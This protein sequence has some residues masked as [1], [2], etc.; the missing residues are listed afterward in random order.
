VIEQL[1]IFFVVPVLVMLIAHIMYIEVEAFLE[2]KELVRQDGERQRQQTNNK[3][4]IQ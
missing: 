2:W 4:E 3:G 1:L